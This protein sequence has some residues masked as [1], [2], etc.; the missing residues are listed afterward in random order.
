MTTSPTSAGV[1]VDPLLSVFPECPDPAAAIASEGQLRAARWKRFRAE[2]P[3]LQWLGLSR[4]VVG[5]FLM[6]T[7]IVAG[8][9]VIGIDIVVGIIIYAWQASQAESEFFQAFA[10]ARGLTCDENPGWPGGEVPLLNHGDKRKYERVLSGR[11]GGGHGSIAEYTYTDVSTDSDGNRSE[12]DFPFTLVHML[13]PPPVA[14]RTESG[15]D[16]GP[17]AAGR[18]RNHPRRTHA[19]AP[20]QPSPGSLAGNRVWQSASSIRDRHAVAGRLALSGPSP[21]RQRLRGS[22]RQH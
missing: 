19:R 10:Q 8:A 21:N 9:V 4:P 16:V 14:E 5:G 20:S 13:L 18:L 3:W 6:A 17:A 22:G 7:S 12:T 2:Y 11:I 15:N 1:A